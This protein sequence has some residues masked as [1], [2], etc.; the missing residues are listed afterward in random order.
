[1]QAAGGI[2]LDDGKYI[3]HG[4][5]RFV[6]GVELK[7]V[8]KADQHCPVVRAVGALHDGVKLLAIGGPSGLE[9]SYQVS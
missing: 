9:F 5:M 7:R 1:M 4:T 3:K 6:V 2:L 8:E